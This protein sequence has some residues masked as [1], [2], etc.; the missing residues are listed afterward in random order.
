MTTALKMNAADKRMQILAYLLGAAHLVFA[1]PKLLGVAAM[2]AEFHRWGFPPWM[3]TFVGVA[4]LLG[5]VGL[6]VRNIRLPS[7]FA[8]GLV[9]IGATVTLA[10]AGEYVQMPV[11]LVIAGL[12]FAVAGHRL[13]Q[14]AAEKAA[15]DA[16]RPAAAS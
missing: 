7:A 14:F 13:M 5:G 4:Q 16:A 1:A 8:M 15:E 9:M 10:A 3:T 12:C 11:T 6:F 2:A